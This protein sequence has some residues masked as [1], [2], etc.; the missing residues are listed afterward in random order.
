MNNSLAYMQTSTLAA[1]SALFDESER[2]K[3]AEASLRSITLSTSRAHGD[4]F[5]RVLVKDLAAALD[6]FYVIAGEIVSVDGDE[7]NRTLAVWAGQDYMDNLTYSLKNTP[8]SEVNDQSMCFH[9]CDIQAAYPL[10]TLLVDMQAQSYVGMPMVGTDGTTLG[11]LVALDTKPIDENKRLLALSLLSIFSARCAAELQ[12]RRRELELEE[13]VEKRT[14]A[15]A[16]ARDLLLQREKLAALGSLVAGIAHAINTPVG[17]ALTTVT[18]LRDYAI[19]LAPQIQAENIDRKRL[20]AAS[21]QLVSGAELI[22]RSLHRASELIS[23]FRMLAITQDT[24]ELSDLNLYDYLT[25]ICIAHQPEMKKRQVQVITALANNLLVRLPAGMLSQIISNLLMNSL[26]HGFVDRSSGTISIVAHLEG[27]ANKDLYVSF[28]DDG[29]GATPE[30]LR[31][32]FEPFFTTRFGQGGSGLGMH[33]VYTLMQ[34]LG[35]TIEVLSPA[36]GGLQ[37][38]LHFPACVV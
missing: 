5:F 36:S 1:P 10:D 3:L 35:G 14:K 28:S 18:A 11:I 19:E 31:R 27:E 24:D 16:N 38:N 2:R 34:R 12:H 23:N 21:S 6:V 37:V 4:E 22:E 7:A 29:V 13:L 30:V 9:P 26:L 25:G 15:L 20:L 32:M 8:C 17:N 33:V